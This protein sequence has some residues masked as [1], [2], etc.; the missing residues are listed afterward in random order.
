[1]EL[2]LNIKIEVQNDEF[3][4]SILSK[5]NFSKRKKNFF[6]KLY[7]YMKIIFYQY[8]FFSLYLIKN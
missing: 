8:I 4:N 6:F 3:S 7:F 1:M 5:I 2:K